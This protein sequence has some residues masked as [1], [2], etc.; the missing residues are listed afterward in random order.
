MPDSTSLNLENLPPKPPFYNNTGSALELLNPAS[1]HISEGDNN[2]AN[3]GIYGGGGA[4]LGGGVGALIQYLRDED[5][6][7]G[8]V[9]GGLVGGGLGVGAKAL[10]DQYFKPLQELGPMMRAD[11][12]EHPIRTSMLKGLSWINQSLNGTDASRPSANGFNAIPP[13][14]MDN[15]VKHLPLTNYSNNRDKFVDLTDKY[16]AKGLK[17]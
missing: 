8:L 4:L 10:G 12:A 2:L 6:L 3:Y 15:I 13:D 7:P 1:K 9:T 5:I 16:R 11:E 17:F 14:E